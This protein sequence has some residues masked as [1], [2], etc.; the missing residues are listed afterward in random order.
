MNCFANN[1]QVESQCA[2]SIFSTCVCV[3]FFFFLLLL[4]LHWS[5]SPGFKFSAKLVKV[6]GHI[7]ISIHNALNFFSLSLLFC[8]YFPTFLLNSSICYRHIWSRCPAN[9]I[10]NIL[11]IFHINI[12]HSSAECKTTWTLWN[13]FSIV[14]MQSPFSECRYIEPNRIEFNK[15]NYFFSWKFYLWLYQITVNWSLAYMS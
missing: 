14:D 5:G 4:K 2:A 6:Y 7:A 15:K 11:Y 9:W 1:L 3:R 8:R 10:R 12:M 13:S